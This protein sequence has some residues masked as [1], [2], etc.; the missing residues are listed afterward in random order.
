MLKA[1]KYRIYPTNSQKLLMAKH[2]GAC[3]FIYNLALE[4]KH[5]AY[6]SNRVHLSSFDLAKQLTDLKKDLVWLNEI[7][8]QS[9]GLAIDDLDSAFVKFFKGAGFPKFKDKYGKQS[10]TA[11]QCSKVKFDKGL[12]YITKFREGIKTKFSRP[13][14]GNIKRITISKTPTG[15]YFASILVDNGVELPTPTNIKEESAVG[16]DLGLKCFL[17]TSNGEII[18]SPKYLR[19][20]E[21]KLKRLSRRHSRKKKG[22]KNREKSRLK[23]AIQHEK[24]ANKRKDFLHKLSSKLISENQTVCIE[25]LNVSGMIQNRKLAKSISDSGWYEFT[26]QLKYKAE[27]YGK[28]VL[29]IGRFEASSKICSTCGTINSLLT[30]SDREW[31]CANCGTLHERDINAAINIKAFALKNIRRGTL[32]SKS[33]ENMRVRNSL[34]QKVRI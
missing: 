21:R 11:R 2:F 23:L 15:K 10:F 14:E 6:I 20:A 22:S 28:N 32:K 34:K 9:L 7:C 26:R 12:L 13:F 25:D 33:V 29:Q 27:W 5:A 18:D 30:L 4:T 3:R 24:V 17:A 19:K 31:A 1:Y 16:I 8:A